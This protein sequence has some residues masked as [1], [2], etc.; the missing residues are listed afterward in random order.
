MFWLSMWMLDKA[1]WNTI[2]KDFIEAM[3]K[4]T[5][6]FYSSKASNWIKNES[7]KDYILKVSI[8]KLP[9]VIDSVI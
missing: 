1:Q 9:P 4:E 2:E 6:A 7:Y 5:A 8:K 3:F